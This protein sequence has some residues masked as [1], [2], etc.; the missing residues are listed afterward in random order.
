MSA[1]P[2]LSERGSAE[3]CN[4]LRL[5]LA[6]LLAAAGGLHLGA[7]PGHLDSAFVAGAFFAATAVGQLLGAVLIATRPSR[8]TI[9]A[10]VV[11]N[12]AVLAI[13]GLSR[14]VGLPIGGALGQREP[15]ALLDGLAAA[16]EILVVAGGLR[17]LVNR[18]ASSAVR[19]PG[20]Q[21]ATVLVGT[22][23]IISGVAGVLSEGG[24]HHHASPTAHQANSDL[25]LEPAETSVDDC[26]LRHACT[27]DHHHG[28]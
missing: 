7:L 16:A 18:P 19:T 27:P 13:W 11:G 1:S 23:M 2:E 26:H 6:G 21:A 15:L 10:V 17:A 3:R 25:I 4:P 28:D 5:A 20:R 24:H 14:T 12:L 9:L 8:R 22:W